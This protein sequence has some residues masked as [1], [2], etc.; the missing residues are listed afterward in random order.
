MGKGAGYRKGEERG[1]PEAIH[2]ANYGRFSEPQAVLH[3]Q[4][5]EKDCSRGIVGRSRVP[6]ATE[7]EWICD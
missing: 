7:A 3:M 6:L 1:C 4:G 5:E 2:L